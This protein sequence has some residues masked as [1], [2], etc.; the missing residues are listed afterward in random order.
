MKVNVTTEKGEIVI[1]KGDALPAKSAPSINIVGTLPAPHQFLIGRGKIDDAKSHLRIEKDN[2][3]I[4]LHL[5]DSDPYTTHVITGELKRDK[6]LAS[7]SINTDK[8]WEVRDFIKFL[9]INKFYFAEPS[10]Q[11]ALI[12]SLQ[13]WNVKI[14]RVIKEHNDNSGNSLSQL[15]TKVAEIDMKT[16]FNLNIPIFQGYNK[17]KFTVEIGFDPGNTS[18]KL[19]LFSDELVQLEME[20]RESIIEQELKKF[21]AYSFAKVVVS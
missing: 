13:K 19:F 3:K 20:Q 7:F 1:R 8:R 6:S 12:A 10:E 21:D 16:K 18:V 5:N 14:E 2:G 17:A 11:E 4:T 15:E 9:R